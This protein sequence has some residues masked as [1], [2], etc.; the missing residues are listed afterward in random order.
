MALAFES[1]NRYE[2]AQGQSSYSPTHNLQTGQGNDR[3]V[4]VLIN[5]EDAQT[6]SVSTVTLGGNAPDGSQGVLVGTGYSGYCWVGWWFDDNLPASTGNTTI[7]I[8]LD[9]AATEAIIVD[10]MEFTGVNQLTAVNTQTDA[11]SGAGNTSVTVTVDVND[12]LAIG[13]FHSGGTGFGSPNNLTQAQAGAVNSSAG[14]SG[15]NLNADTPNVTIG[16]NSL[17][18]RRGF[19]GA[20]FQPAPESSSSSSSSSSRSSSSSSSSSSESSSSESSSS[21][22]SSFSVPS[23]SYVPKHLLENEEG[24]ESYGYVDVIDIPP[25]NQSDYYTWLTGSPDVPTSNSDYTLQYLKITKKLL[26]VVQEDQEFYLCREQNWMNWY[27]WHE[28]G[29]VGPAPDPIGFSSSSSSASS[30]SSSSSASVAGSPPVV[31]SG[32]VTAIHPSGTSH[33]FSAPS[34]SDG[35]V[36][37][38]HAA[39]NGNRTMTGPVGFSVAFENVQ[40][41]SDRTTHSLWYKTASSDPVK[42]AWSLD[43]AEEGVTMTWSVSN[44]GGIDVI[45]A[46]NTGDS[47]SVSCADVTSTVDNTLILRL[48]HT[49]N[50][51]LPHSLETGYTWIDSVADAAAASISVQYDVKETAGAVGQLFIDIAFTVEWGGRTVIIKPSA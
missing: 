12:S 18:T 38:V 42:Y 49:G 14:G 45:S 24:L 37:Y 27:R 15:Y 33:S 28:G 1:T 9:D 3:M 35:D 34:H 30:S 8:T 36:I 47:N 48:V 25:E 32:Q 4:S 31:N 46:N 7:A 44:D 21:S 22:S 16:W 51:T 39:T 41:F 43:V 40:S 2:S 20:V 19:V 10:V 23:N 6:A 26:E 29:E 17:T 11:Q 5:F 50:N 13:H